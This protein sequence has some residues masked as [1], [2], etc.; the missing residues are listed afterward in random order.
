MYAPFHNLNDCRIMSD[1]VAAMHRR[2]NLSCPKG[3]LIISNVFD[4][5]IGIIQIAITIIYL[6]QLCVVLWLFDCLFVHSFFP[7]L[8]GERPFDKKL[9]VHALEYKNKEQIVGFDFFGLCN[10]RPIAIRGS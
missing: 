6:I 2:C 10:F 4:L 5:A 1:F 7:L 3:S 9:S 8:I